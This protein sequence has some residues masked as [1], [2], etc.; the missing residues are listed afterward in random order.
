LRTGSGA[1]Y[2][3]GMA[4]HRERLTHGSTP[5]RDDPRLAARPR[6]FV[7][8]IVTKTRDLD[9]PPTWAHVADLSMT[10]VGE[11]ASSWRGPS[12][13]FGG[14]TMLDARRKAVRELARALGLSEDELAEAERAAGGPVDMTLSLSR[15][16]PGW[17][18]WACVG[19]VGEAAVAQWLLEHVDVS[20]ETRDLLERP[21][22]SVADL[23]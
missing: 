11:L 3:L 13:T 21:W 9:V 20:A 19:M 4:D 10:Q 16:E 1:T 15:S 6:P 17:P 8:G 5:F 2:T 7:V 12:T 18:G 23:P 22:L 14:P